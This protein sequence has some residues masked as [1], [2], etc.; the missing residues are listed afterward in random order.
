MAGV[1]DKVAEATL[2]RWDDMKAEQRLWLPIWQELSEYIQPRKGNISFKRSSA[3]QQTDK[4]FDSTAPHANE[5][6]AASMQGALTSAAFR[7]FSLALKG[8][9]LEDEHDVAVDLEDCSE[10]MY[11]AFNESNFASETH[12]IYLDGPCFGTTAIFVE[13]RRPTIGVPGGALRFTALPP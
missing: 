2:Q 11:D 1:V 5:L 4:L 6:L 7:W 10:D 9:D 3:Q 8:I 12:E 13:E